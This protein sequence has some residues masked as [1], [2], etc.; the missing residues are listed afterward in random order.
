M[1]VHNSMESCIIHVE[2]RNYAYLAVEGF[3]DS[4]KTKEFAEKL[5]SLCLHN[6]IG[7]IMF[8]SSKLSVIKPTDMEW[9]FEQVLQPLRYCSIDKV[10]FL[11]P[12]STFGIVSVKK[13]IQHIEN[14][15][16]GIF[17]NIEQA[18]TWLFKSTSADNTASKISP[19]ASA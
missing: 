5:V 2:S 9:I 18:E 12:E 8:D 11:M 19:K 6:K 7:M 10:A 16:T 15:S 1:I 3:I 17:R 13:L 4:K 14:C